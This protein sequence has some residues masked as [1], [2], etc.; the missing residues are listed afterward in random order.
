MHAGQKRRQALHMTHCHRVMR[1]VECGLSGSKDL[2]NRC[3]HASQTLAYISDAI[4]K[5]LERG[6]LSEGVGAVRGRGEGEQR[7]NVHRLELHMSRLPNSCCICAC[8]SALGIA[9]GGSCRHCSARS[10]CT[11]QAT[12]NARV[13]QLS[14]RTG[15]NG[16]PYGSVCSGPAGQHP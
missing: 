13:H 3:R 9:P 15:Q 8:A 1:Q 2:E 4:Q 16:L 6:L 5:G 12:T 11:S 14:E 10:Q 7:L